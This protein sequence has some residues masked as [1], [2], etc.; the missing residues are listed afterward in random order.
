MLFCEIM[1]WLV[2]ARGEWSGGA[3]G[4]CWASQVCV[5][6]EP[7]ESPASHVMRFER[8]QTDWCRQVSVGAGTAGTSG[9]TCSTSRGTGNGV[10]SVTGRDMHAGFAVLH[11]INS[12][13]HHAAANSLIEELGAPE[14]QHRLCLA[15]HLP[16]FCI[17]LPTVAT[18]GR[19]EPSG[20]AGEK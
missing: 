2:Q 12:T 7:S 8:T 6:S 16:R 4:R 19:A 9:T 20:A 10:N 15:L 13:L 1:H 18:P 5:V 17:A 14:E 3:S 11:S